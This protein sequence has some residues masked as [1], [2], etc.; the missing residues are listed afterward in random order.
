M[1]AALYKATN[2]PGW[3]NNDNWLSEAPI[4]QWYG[5]ITSCGG[6]VTGLVLNDNQLAGPIPPELGGLINLERLRL[7]YNRLSGAVPQELGNLSKLEELS[8]AGNQLTGCIPREL[9]GIEDNDF[10]DT[11]LPFC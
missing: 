4:S 6:A 5:V 2:G 8:L 3:N 7:D 11:N 9:Q 1:L 10:T